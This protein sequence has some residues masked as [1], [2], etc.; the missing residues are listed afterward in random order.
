VFD[1]FL[2]V[3]RSLDLSQGGLG[4]GLNLVRRFVEMHGGSVQAASGGANCGSEFTVRLPLA[5]DSFVQP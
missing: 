4:I 1:M 5:A 3:D 2:Q